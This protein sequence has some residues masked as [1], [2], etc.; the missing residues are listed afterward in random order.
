M[1]EFLYL[2]DPNPSCEFGPEASFL[3]SQT[4]TQEQFYYMQLKIASFTHQATFGNTKKV[5]SGCLPKG[6]SAFETLLLKRI[7]SFEMGKIFF[8]GYVLI[9]L[10]F[11]HDSLRGEINEYKKAQSI[12][13]D[14]KKLC[15]SSQMYKFI[16]R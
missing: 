13:L 4:P 14:L 1:S 8:L 9:N 16:D 7:C 10:S 12:I 15:M 2:L 6:G 11:N 5:A 3:V